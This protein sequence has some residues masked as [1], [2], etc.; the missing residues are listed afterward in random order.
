M[1]GGIEG[2]VERETALQTE[3]ILLKKEMTQ[4]FSTKASSVNPIKTQC[5]IT[6]KITFLF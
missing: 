1:N 4:N 2:G 6:E 3:I 5:K